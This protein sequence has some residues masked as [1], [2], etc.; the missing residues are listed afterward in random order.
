MMLNVDEHSHEFKVVA[1]SP[2]G[3]AQRSGLV[4][5]GDV[6]LKIEGQPLRGLTPQQV[7]DLITG[8]RD[9]QVELLIQTPIVYDVHTAHFQELPFAG[10]RDNKKSTNGANYAGS[11]VYGA[12]HLPAGFEHLEELRSRQP[13]TSPSLSVR[14]VQ[15]VRAVAGVGAQQEAASIPPQG[16]HGSI[17]PQS[18]NIPPQAVKV[19]DH[20]MVQSPVASGAVNL[21]NLQ[22][23]LCV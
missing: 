8:P 10:V 20:P 5:V 21:A 1:L 12:G 11:Q 9:T 15:L 2:G 22:V 3:P 18:V 4:R 19:E 7:V 6:I 13:Y 16:L 17:P 23:H 14:R